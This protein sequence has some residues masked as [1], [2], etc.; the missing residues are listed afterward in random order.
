MNLTNQPNGRSKG[1]AKQMV[2]AGRDSWEI[3]ITGGPLIERPSDPN[4]NYTD[5]V[6]SYWPASIAAIQYYTNKITTQYVGH[7]NGCRVAL[8]SLEKYQTTGR[9]NVA[10]VQNLQTGSYVTVN[11]QG[12]QSTP[13]V[14]TFV[15]TGCP[16]AFEGDS[17]VMS[18]LRSIGDR[19]FNNLEQSSNTHPTVGETLRNILLAS[20]GGA[21]IEGRMSLNLL[22]DYKRLIDQTSDPQPGN[23]SV[24]KSLIFYGNTPAFSGSDFVVSIEDNLA[25]HNGLISQ[26]KDLETTNLNHFFIVDGSNVKRKIKEKLG[27]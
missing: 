13:I 1:L 22:R 25:I 10:K 3:E 21:G 4:Y 23:F 2:E 12:S 26:N 24:N 14:N 7:S 8:S 6:D 20:P 9:S 11:L 27:G 17:P 5:L 15:G 18:A 19:A 16:G